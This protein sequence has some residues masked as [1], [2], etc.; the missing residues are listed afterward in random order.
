MCAPK[1]KP[2]GMQTTLGVMQIKFSYD[3]GEIRSVAI[4]QAADVADNFQAAK[5][6]SFC[7]QLGFTRAV[8]D[9][10]YT[11]SALSGLYDFRSCNR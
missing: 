6:D 10:V 5:K 9:A 3:P 8:A 2:H 1:E 11:V 7:R 4:R